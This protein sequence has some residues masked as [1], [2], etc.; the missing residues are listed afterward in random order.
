MNECNCRNA[1]GGTCSSS[2]NSEREEHIRELAIYQKALT[3]F[4]LSPYPMYI[5]VYMRKRKAS[6]ISLNYPRHLR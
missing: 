6:L 3:C 2:S 1:I 4:I 5:L